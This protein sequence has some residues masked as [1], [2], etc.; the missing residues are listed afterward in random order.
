MGY[1]VKPDVNLGCYDFVIKLM[2][3]KIRSLSGTG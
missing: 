1:L 2:P 3:I